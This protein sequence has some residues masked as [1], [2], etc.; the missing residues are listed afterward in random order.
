M[1]GLFHYI[2]YSSLFGRYTYKGLL[3]TNVRLVGSCALKASVV[4]WWSKP[5]TNT[6][7][8]YSIGTLVNT[9]L[10]SWWTDQEWTNFHRPAMSI[11]RYIWVGQHSPNY[12]LTVDQVL[13]EMLV[14]CWLHVSVD[15]VSIECQLRVNQGYWLTLDR[16]CLQN[17]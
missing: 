6:L 2:T 4:E 16:R 12:R 1:K 5:L 3:I 10:T 14:D 13:I 11:N 7:D 8:R 9:R 17:T 15:Q